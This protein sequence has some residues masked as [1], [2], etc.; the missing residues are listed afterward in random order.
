MTIQLNDALK[1][2]RYWHLVDLGITNNR[3]TLNRWIERGHFPAP[4][5]LGPNSIAWRASE[6]QEWLD[7]RSS[8]TPLE[9]A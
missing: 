8:R 7:N 3:M 5:Q 1:V 6:V 4:I 9:A 2:L